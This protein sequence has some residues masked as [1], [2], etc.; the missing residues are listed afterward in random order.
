MVTRDPETHA[1]AVASVRL[2]ARAEVL[3]DQLGEHLKTLRV[4]IHEQDDDNERSREGRR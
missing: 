1:L 3:L 4:F 2:V